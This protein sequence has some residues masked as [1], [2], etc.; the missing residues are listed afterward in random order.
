MKVV[1][2]DPDDLEE[3][4]CPFPLV[5]RVILWCVVLILVVGSCTLAWEIRTTMHLN[6]LILQYEYNENRMLRSQQA[7]YKHALPMWM[8]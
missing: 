1:Q 2:I 8:P 5:E 4:S 7:L 3:T 6:N